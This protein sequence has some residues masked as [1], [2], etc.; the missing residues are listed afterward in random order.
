MISHY[1]HFENS[2]SKS[3]VLLSGNTLVLI[4]EVTASDICG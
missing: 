4:D 1:L 2:Y 3:V